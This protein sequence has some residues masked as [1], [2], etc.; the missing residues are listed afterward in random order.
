MIALPVIVIGGVAVRSA[1]A[2][3]GMAG[4]V[5]VG[6]AE[7]DSPGWRTTVA[8]VSWGGNK[9]GVRLGGGVRRAIAWQLVNTV[10][11]ANSKQ[12]MKTL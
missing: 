5:L 6:V 4:S 7:G 11:S 10:I 3:I 12:T 9:T 2:D 8:G 1:D